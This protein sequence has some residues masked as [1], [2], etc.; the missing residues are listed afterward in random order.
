[1]ADLL[2]RLVHPHTPSRSKR[3]ALR[4]HPGNVHAWSI[5]TATVLLV[6]IAAA[7]VP[8]FT[9][10]GN[11]Q[12]IMYSVAAVGIGAIGMAMVTLCGYLFMLSMG[13]MAAVSTV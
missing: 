5:R 11:T 3:L 8:N 1:M 13:A 7:F 10:F 9:S 12:A 4:V 6:V 2:Q